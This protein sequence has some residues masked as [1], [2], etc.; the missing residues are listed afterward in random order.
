MRLTLYSSFKP[1]ARFGG[2]VRHRRLRP[3]TRIMLVAFLCFAAACVVA[4][5]IWAL[6]P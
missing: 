5:V 6:N 1:P 4:L 3:V 2:Q